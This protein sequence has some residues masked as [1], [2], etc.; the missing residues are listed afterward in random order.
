M[1]TLQTHKP[2]WFVVTIK[3][4]FLDQLNR[5]MLHR[6]RLYLRNK[7]FNAIKEDGKYMDADDFEYLKLHSTR[8][9]S[10]YCVKK[11]KVE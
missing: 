11:F 5:Q 7:I 9:F 10:N 2:T 6:L 3:Q 8:D 4:L 1:T